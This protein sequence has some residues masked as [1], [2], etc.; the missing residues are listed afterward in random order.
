M[1]IRGQVVLFTD[2]GE[3]YYIDV[4]LTAMMKIKIQRMGEPSISSC[5][6]AIS[7]VMG[8]FR[9]GLIYQASVFGIG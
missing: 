9:N 8:N 4:E 5:S 7:I 1:L 3:N 2:S 6:A